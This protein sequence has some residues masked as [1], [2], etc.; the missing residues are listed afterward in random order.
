[1]NKPERR[2]DIDWLRLLIVL[3]LIPFH[4]AWLMVSVPGFSHIDKGQLGAKILRTYVLFMDQWHMHLLF[5]LSGVSTCFALRF[6]LPWQYVRERARRLLVPLI[7]GVLVINPSM[8]YFHW[9]T[10]HVVR[11]L[12]DAYIFYNPHYLRA[13]YNGGNL[14]CG[15]LWFIAYLLVFSLVALPLFLYMRTES[16]Q[17]LTSRLATFFEGRGTILLL[18]APL[19]IIRA[20]LSVKWPGA[21]VRFFFTDMVECLIFIMLL[22]YG[23][24]ICSDPG[25]WRAIE[26]SV[27]TS[28]LLAV[29]CMSLILTL[30][31]AGRVPTRG[32]TPEYMLYMA[33][34]GFNMWFWLLTVLGIGRKYLNLGSKVLEYLR[35]GSYA[36]YVLHLT[37][38]V[39]IGAQLVK[40]RSG[41]M[42]EFLLISVMSLLTTMAI[43][44]L[45]LRR[46]NVTRF[47]FGMIPKERKRKP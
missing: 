23:Y 35:E 16:G 37:V 25:F 47:L 42:I 14:N 39:V 19:A 8:F 33:L 6:R 29:A 5:L 46:T 28:L 9:T 34:C 31:W 3:N 12:R 7:F 32:Y 36:F 41:A 44:D 15:H 21:G 38:T 11:N 26:K 24:L 27:K 43:Y 30:T 4:A 20:T 17:R 2:Y 45:L 1:M 10:P 18:G 40:L 22:I 13:L